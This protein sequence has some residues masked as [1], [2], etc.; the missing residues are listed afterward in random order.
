MLAGAPSVQVLVDDGIWSYRIY[1][2]LMKH[3][4]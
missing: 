1:R 4:S 2:G 3:Q